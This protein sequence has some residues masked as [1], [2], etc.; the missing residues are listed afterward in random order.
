MTDTDTRRVLLVFEDGSWVLHVLCGCQPTGHSV[1]EAS[2]L[3][4]TAEMLLTTPHPWRPCPDTPTVL[5]GGRG[6]IKAWGEARNTAVV[7]IAAPDGAETT[8]PLADLDDLLTD[9]TT[10]RLD[11]ADDEDADVLCPEAACG[12][13]LV[14]DRCTDGDCPTRS[15]TR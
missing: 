1:T 4:E 13:Y 14:D 2:S 9:T 12:G 11:A 3:A 15:T 7:V 8:R 5:P 10:G 6:R